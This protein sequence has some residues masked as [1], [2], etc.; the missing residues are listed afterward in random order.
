MILILG[1][2]AEGRALSAALTK[3]GRPAV[4]SMAGRT[5]APLT[6]GESRIGGFGGVGGLVAYL[7]DHDVTQVVD[8][9]HPFAARISEN[10]AE[11]CRVARVPLLRLARPGWEGHALA[12][13][14]LWVSGHDEAARVTAGLETDPVLLTVGKQH[15]VDYAEHLAGRRVVARM[16]EPPSSAVPGAWELLLARGPFT[17]DGELALFRRLGIAA[18]VTKDSGGEHTAAKLEAAHI[19]GAAVVM[20]GRPA[21]PGGVETVG[22]V[23]D[24]LARLSSD[25]RESCINLR[26]R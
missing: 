13:T 4:L 8:A 20:I 9:T 25:D 12:D 2:T 15:T 21:A 1:G 5:R 3:Q 18:L 23:A 7:Q 19:V 26:M 10:A 11:A 17:L 6:A 16:T 24:A 14:W 22:T